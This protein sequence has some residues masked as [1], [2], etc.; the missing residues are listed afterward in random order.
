M[1]SLLQMLVKKIIL[2][3]FLKYLAK[4]F[5]LLL[6]HSEKKRNDLVAQLV[7]HITFN[8][9]ALGSSPSGITKSYNSVVAFL[10]HLKR[11]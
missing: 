5:Y 11:F 9:G 7:E 2:N 1:G 8:D 10:L 4:K 3:Y 6:L